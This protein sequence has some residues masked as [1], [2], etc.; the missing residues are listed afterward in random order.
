MALRTQSDRAVC[1]DA[2]YRSNIEGTS[3][4]KTPA[5]DD[6]TPAALSPRTIGSTV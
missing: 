2:A 1:A 6:S 3:Y 5:T 4:L